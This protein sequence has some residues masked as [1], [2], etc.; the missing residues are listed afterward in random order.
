[1]ARNE[2]KYMEAAIAV[3]EELS[4][5]RAARRL[6]LSQPAI[7]K[8]IAE[9][10]DILGVVLFIRDHHTVSVTDA[11]R[12]YVEEARISV[13]HSE[14]A[15]QV[16]RAAGQNAE[17]ILNVGRT[18]YADPFFTSM[19]LT[20]RLPLFPRL[21]LNLS[22]GYSC[23]L[24]H[25]VLAG[26]LDVAVAVEPPT[27]GKLTGVKI[28]E[29]PFYVVMGR[30]NP[31]AGN[32]SIRLEQLTG[33]RWLLFQRSIHPLLYDLVQKLS[34]EMRVVPS[35]IQHFMVPEEAIPLLIDP[36]AIVIVPKSGAL[37]IARDGLTMRPLDEEKLVMTTLLISRT[38][39]SSPV[40][41][42]LFRGFMRRMNYRKGEDQMSL[43]IPV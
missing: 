32:R 8:Y 15:V 28:D 6:H 2:L 39:N 11:G 21:K 1:M 33:R 16:A 29:S 38:D 31:L 27:S 7:T 19:L 18:P 22:S 37:R 5:S 25:E 4:F 20:M 3:A 13:L 41:S 26:E 14:R 42:E 36:T 40:L 17:T 23:D 10:E 12:A 34:R 43:P 9:L 24:A 30:E 35:D